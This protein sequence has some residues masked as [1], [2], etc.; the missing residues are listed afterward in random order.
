MR[1]VPRYVIDKGGVGIDDAEVFSDEEL[2][3]NLFGPSSGNPIQFDEAQRHRNYFTMVYSSDGG[4]LI[5]RDVLIRDDDLDN[6]GEGDTFGDLTRMLVG[7]DRPGDEP[8]VQ[9]YYSQDDGTPVPIDARAGIPINQ[10][11]AVPFLVVD[12]AGNV[13]I[14]FPS[15]DGLLVY[16]DSSFNGFEDEEDK[17]DFLLH[18]AQPFYISRMTGAVIRG[19]RGEAEP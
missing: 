12:D 3:N 14:N 11:L 17:R 6:D 5:R 16:D 7:Y 13:A 19:P 9:D 15:V 4:L 18:T 8:N 2:A 10:R 1:A